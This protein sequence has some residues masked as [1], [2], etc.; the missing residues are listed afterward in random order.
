VLV[1]SGL[2][3][4][5]ILDRLVDVPLA[6]SPV[7]TGLGL[8]LLFGRN[9]LLFPV[10]EALGLKVAFAVPGVVVATLFVTVPFVVREVALVLE[11]LGDSEEQA[12]ATL[13]ASP[14]QTFVRVTLPNLSHGL[15]LGSALTAARSLGEFGAVLVVGGASR[16]PPARPRRSSTARS[17]AAISPPPTAWR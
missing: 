8:L 7:M 12:A 17:K 16:S 11:E 4:R 6:V 9:G 15:V 14:W 5:W 3:G 10:F 2:R 1:R 13:G